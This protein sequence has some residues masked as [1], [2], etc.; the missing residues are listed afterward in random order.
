MH[1]FKVKL[2]GRNQ[3]LSLIDIGENLKQLASITESMFGVRVAFVPV[4]S[5]KSR[6]GQLS[7]IPEG[8]QLDEDWEDMLKTIHTFISK[9]LK[10]EEWKVACLKLSS[11]IDESS[12]ASYKAIYWH[13]NLQTELL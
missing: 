3:Q 11:K 7:C 6:G 13:I 9:T 10:K 1:P 12:R 2:Y 8:Q 4:Q 5:K